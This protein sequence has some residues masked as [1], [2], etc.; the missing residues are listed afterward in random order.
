M[1]RSS[2]GRSAAATL[3]LLAAGCAGVGG[4]DPGAL[5]GPQG[6]SI[7]AGL[8]Q[9][10]EVGTT[11]AV[12]R[13]S[14]AGGYLSD[15]LIRIGLPESLQGMARGLRAVGFGGPIDDFEV[16]MNRA[17][18]RAAGEAKDVFWQAIR[19]MTFSDAQAILRGGD[20][21]ATDY[22]ER[23]TRDTLRARFQP[24]VSERMDEVGVVRSYDQLV[25]RYA[26]IPFTKP[27]ALDIRSYVTE[28]ALDGLFT[29]L[30]QEE[31]RIRTDPAARTTELLRQVF[32]SQ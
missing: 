14:A 7:S 9:A 19:Q 11:R 31:R 15:P 8:K 17:A 10:L 18:E 12:T 13:T 6:S 26:A 2:R 25:S 29:V 30:G 20:T 21:A 23:T 5:L 1:E 32:G 3:I 28:K 16:A 4:F 27:P 24:I 22:F